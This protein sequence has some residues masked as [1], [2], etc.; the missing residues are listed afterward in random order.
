M[1]KKSNEAHAGQAYTYCELID[2]NEKNNKE[3]NNYTI[4]LVGPT[5]VKLSM[6]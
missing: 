4:Y 2:N 3:N 1:K 5:S 6:K